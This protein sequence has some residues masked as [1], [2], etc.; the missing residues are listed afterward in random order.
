MT[1]ELPGTAG[2]PDTSVLIEDLLSR[3]TFGSG[4]S[5]I[6]VACS[7]GPDSTALAVLAA[8]TGRPVVLHHVDH[9]IRPGSGGDIAVVEG[10]AKRLGADVMAYRVEVGSASNLEETARRARRAVL[11]AGVAT[12]HTM[13]DQAETVLIN[14]L[15]GT[16]ISG[17]GA[18]EP[19]PRHPILGLRR[20]ETHAVCEQ[21]D[22]EP[23]HDESNADTEILRNDVR[24]RL[25]PLLGEMSHRD[26]VPL[27]ARLARHA[28]S[29]SEL[30]DDLAALVIADPQEVSDLRA[31]P[32]PLALRSLRAWL[33]EARSTEVSAHPP[34]TA[35]LDRT[36]AVVEGRARSTELAG[37]LRLLRTK[38]RLRVE[39]PATGTLRRV[40]PKA[41]DRVAPAWAEK[42]LGDILISG[43]AIRAR[44]A[45]LG[46]EIT[47]DYAENPPLLVCVLK[48][49]MHFISDLSRAIEL[50][51]EIDFMAVSSYGS[52]TKTSGVVRIVKDLDADLTDRHVLVVEDIVDSGLTLNYLR[53][54]LGARKPAS[55]E[56]CALLI[57]EG[58]QRVEQVL[59]YTGFTIPPT[60][61]VGYGLDVAE[62]FRNLQDVYTYVGDETG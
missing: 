13:D 48:G 8:S 50:P 46:A 14:L 35:E 41:I 24:A 6:A 47:A 36:M 43:D 37:G 28:R 16:G 29:E 30:L 34:T 9:G 39:Q 62:R 53:K 20:S 40:E 25:L 3:C 5:T 22:L 32:T 19:G 55:I 17:L 44:V 45:E 42:D 31:A 7:G 33:T 23:V 54:Y 4:T 10:L 21:L 15:R 26:P 58:E 49:A 51:V 1:G 27:L 57:K 12:G 60:F 2:S 52:A 11:P 56:V 61:V 38:G 18:M 59:R